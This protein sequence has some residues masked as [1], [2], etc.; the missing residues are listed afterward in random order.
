VPVMNCIVG[1]NRINNQKGMALVVT[2]LALA[3]ITALV[4][5]FSYAVYTGTQDLYN[6]RDLQRLSLMAESGVNVSERLLIDMLSRSTYSYPGYTELPVENPFEDFKGVIT[7]R[8]ED[9]SSKFN[10]NTI[11]S[12]N[13]ILNTDAYK[14]FKKLLENLSLNEQ[15]ADRIA[16]WIDPDSEARL[17][18]SEVGAKNSDMVSVDEILLIKGISRNDYNTLLPYITVYG[19]KDF[20]VINVNGAEAPVLMCILDSAKGD[21]PI[22]KDIAGRIIK[23]RENMPFENIYQF[24]RFAGTGL[25]D[26]QI[27]VKGT[28]YYIKSTAESGGLKRII[29]TVINTDKSD[30]EYW[31]EY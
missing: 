31:K 27:T 12:P 1:V 30:I 6:W 24:N 3:I 22:N 5:E 2:L 17:S 10:V 28:N 8:L 18:D 4:V 16:D 11:I 9:E 26:K 13:G 25:A 29:E 23:Y 19:K 15:I 7:V 20:P 14:S 21:F